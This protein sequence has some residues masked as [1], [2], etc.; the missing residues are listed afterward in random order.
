[1]DKPRNF[2]AKR[3]ANALFPTAEPVSAADVITGFTVGRLKRIYGGLWVG[4]TLYL[5]ADSLVFCPN[6][7]NRSVHKGDV[8]RRVSLAEVASVTD[9]FGLVTGIV[10]VELN[11]GTE[12]KFRCYGATKFAQLI[13]NQ[14]SGSAA[15]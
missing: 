3:Q 13:Q 4:G 9:Q 14:I 12:F 7:L 8:S 2:V 6:A 15:S 5:L 1:M 11:D 10:R